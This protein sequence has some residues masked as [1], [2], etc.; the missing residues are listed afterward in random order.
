M[1]NSVSF[2][3]I[4]DAIQVLGMRDSVVCLHSSLKSFGHLEGGA[5]TVIRAFRQS[6]CTLLVPTFSYDCE[7]APPPGWDLL[8]NGMDSNPDWGVPQAYDKPGRMISREMGAIPA[9]LLAD[10]DAVRS[11]HPLN[12]F[13]ALGPLA[14]EI[15]AAQD[16]LNV[17]GPYKAIYAAIPAFVIL[18]GVDLTSAT[19]I[20]F[21]EEKA[22]R[23]MFRRWALDG[24]G[25]PREVEVGSCSD[26]FNRLQPHLTEIEK[27]VAVGASRWR[28]S[29][30]RLF[31]DQLARAIARDP[32]LTHCPDPDCPRCRDMLK[33][34]P[35]L[36]SRGGADVQGTA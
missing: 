8:Q 20:H 5:D 13:A 30:F 18:A 34:G 33:G 29:P 4:L 15:I 3:Q 11:D 14:Q 32:A 6:G 2:S 36:A 24:N 10:A 26:G 31:I 9:R 22:G 16:F 27:S 28:V 7:T 17:Y 12:S 21:A 1:D 23:R 25:L 35:I 19:P